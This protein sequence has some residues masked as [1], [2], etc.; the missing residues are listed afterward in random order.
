MTPGAAG[1]NVEF[2]IVCPEDESARLNVFS[3]IDETFFR[4][5]PFTQSEARQIAHV[6]GRNACAIL[7]DCG[8][9]VAHGMLQGWDEGHPPPSQASSSR[10]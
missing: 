1:E 4:G 3:D 6:S 2:R 7:V 8:H 5:R 10:R 9:A